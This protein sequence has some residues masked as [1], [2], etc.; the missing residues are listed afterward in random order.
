MTMD[1]GY[2]SITLRL[3]TQ[4]VYEHK[5]HPQHLTQ[6]HLTAHHSPQGGTLSGLEAETQHRGVPHGPP[7]LRGVPRSAR[8]GTGYPGAPPSAQV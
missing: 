3:K 5:T 4:A 8:G 2:D 7:W 6:T 1:D